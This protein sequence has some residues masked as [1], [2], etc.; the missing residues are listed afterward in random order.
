MLKGFSWQSVWS[1]DQQ[2]K[3]GETHQPSSKNFKLGIPAVRNH[4]PTRS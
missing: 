4:G 1:D 3:Y 2:L